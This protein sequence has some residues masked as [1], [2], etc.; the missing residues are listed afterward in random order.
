[1]GKR[2][3]VKILCNAFIFC[4]NAVLA[5]DPSYGLAVINVELTSVKQKIEGF[6]GNGAFYEGW[7]SAHPQKEEIYS[8]I[9]GGLGTSI[10]RIRNSY[11]TG[12]YPEDMQRQ[13]E[14][15]QAAE[16]SLGHPVKIMI[17]SWSPPKYLK[18]NG[19]E[20][21]GTL[22]RQDPYGPKDPTNPYKYDEFAEWWVNSLIAYEDLGITA[23]YISIQNE[24]SLNLPYPCCVFTKNE[25]VDWAG[26][27][28]A[29]DAVF[30]QLSTMEEPPNILG[31]D[32]VHTYR[33]RQYIDAHSDL[34]QFYGY[35]H[36]LYGMGVGETQEDRFDNP[37]SFIP[38][39]QSFR[40]KYG[41]KSI[42]QTEYCRIKDSDGFREAIN[43]AKHIHNSLVEE[44]VAAYMVYGL[45]WPK[46][47]EDGLGLVLIDNPGT[48]SDPGY[49]IQDTY[50]AL[51]HYSKFI[52]PGYSRINITNPNVSGL[53]ASAFKSP[54][55]KTIV[56]VIINPKEESEGFSVS[57]LG[58]YIFYQVFRTDSTPN[59]N[60]TNITD[61]WDGSLPGKSI[62]TIIYKNSGDYSHDLSYNS[63]TPCRIVD[64]RIS[65]GG[66]TIIG[67]AQRNFIA[68]GLCGVP[69]GPA[70]AM[71]V[72]ITAVNATGSG[73]LTVFSYPGT[74]PI[75]S[76]LNYGIVSGLP[77]IANGVITPICETDINT[78]PYDLSIYVY[79]TTDVVVDVLGYF[80][81]PP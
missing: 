30:Q 14:A 77:A 61:N 78:C 66:G 75:T 27:D 62:T 43:T 24:P 17:S 33:A 51:K 22:A 37:D 21:G 81:P 53:R 46:I 26:H 41:Y 19:N 18:S 47:D 60:C 57:G 63:V 10:Y 8:T 76:V 29:V 74:P 35:A 70:K 64:T 67:G 12:Y 23:T 65:Q 58:A 56:L 38:E 1:M 80:A 54:D 68:T 2:L 20:V 79:R 25:T 31:P 40:D 28:S 15:I 16:I 59:N 49:T 50:Y 4:I 71:M 34:T 72:N 69:H 48:T 73:Y 6:G 36:H 3:I 39:M 44:N 13:A 55:E 32:T 45:F 7:L 42:F 52:Q 11:E 9:F 5:S